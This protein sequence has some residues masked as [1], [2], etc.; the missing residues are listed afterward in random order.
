VR[1]LL[2]HNHYGGYSGES[3]VMDAQEA[4]LKSHGHE[5]RKYTRSSAEIDNM[6]FGKYW[7]F[8]SGIYNPAS[9]R[10]MK[11]L[12]EEYRP[13]I[14]HIHN[15][16]PLISPSVL[17]QIHSMGIPVVMTVHNYRLVCPNGLFF[18]RFG[19]C[20]KCEGGREW[21][22][23]RYN[24]LQSYNKSLG[25][26]LRNAWARVAEYYLENVDAFLC[27]TEFHLEKLV[28]NGYA[29]E[30]GH[31]LPNFFDGT[32]EPEYPKKRPG[33]Y[34][35]FAGR[36]SRE[37]GIDLI[38]NAARQ[39]PDIPFKLAGGVGEQDIEAGKPSNVEVVGMLKGASLQKFYQDAAL[40]LLS[41][42]WYEGFP[43]VLLEAM[44]YGL[45]II[46]PRLGGLPE[47]VDDGIT[48]ML[49]EAGNSVDLAKKI[50]I[51][52]DDKGLLTEMGKASYAKMGREYLPDTYYYKLYEIYQSLE[53]SA[54][55][56]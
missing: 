30:R 4:L 5:V 14:V 46:C 31:V 52:W 50:R 44:N 32:N 36:I 48:G 35:A 51:M 3:A 34:V 38:Y 45:P 54:K 9:I 7:A 19:I 33:S 39:L 21:N 16:Y 18:N 10:A 40:F 55:W 25:Y 22:C 2:V 27:L 17:P 20:E 8:F 1:I 24:C 12:L 11:K 6:K 37:K 28:L 49:Y 29:R 15:L 26:A 41:S 56:S 13:D 53:K 42:V 47:I 43:M 23:L